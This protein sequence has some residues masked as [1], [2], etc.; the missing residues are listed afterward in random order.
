MVKYKLV[1]QFPFYVDWVSR[2][3]NLPGKFKGGQSF[4]DLPLRRAVYPSYGVNTTNAAGAMIAS[5]TWGQDSARLGAF[6]GDFTSIPH[7]VSTT[8]RDLARLNNVTHQ[9]LL[10]QFVDYHV[11][12]WYGH[13][14]SIGAFASFAPAQFSTVMPALLQPAYFGKVHFA[15][16]ALSSGHGWIIGALNSAYRA[17]AE[18]L[19]VEGL[20]GKL[21]ELVDTWGLVDEVDMGWY[22][23]G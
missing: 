15:G 6:Y 14:F 8:I 18:V 19:A 23:I 11:W 22:K 1:S 17:V 9:F 2:W 3:E 13:E 16:E 5:Y 7:V 21:Q 4:T 20:A 12:N 10:D